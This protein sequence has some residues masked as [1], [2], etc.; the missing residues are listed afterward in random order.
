MKILHKY[1]MIFIQY[2]IMKKRLMELEKQIDQ[3]R[4]YLNRYYRNTEMLLSQIHTLL[5]FTR[6]K[7][8]IQHWFRINKLAIRIVSE[9]LN[10]KKLV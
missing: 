8:K 7:D 10:K 9:L 1:D 2:S 5:N 6:E 4:S 3:N